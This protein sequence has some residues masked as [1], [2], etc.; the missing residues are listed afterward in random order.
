MKR[1]VI[2]LGATLLL[3]PVAF[4]QTP[5]QHVQRILNSDRFK[6]AEAFVEADYDRFINEIVQLTEIAA[7]PFKEDK[8]ARVYL[9]MLRQTW[10]NQCRDGC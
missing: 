3:C 6:A 2:A 1:V 9:D 10:S 5:D 7:P 4:A 8:R